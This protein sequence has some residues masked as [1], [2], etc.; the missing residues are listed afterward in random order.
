MTTDPTDEELCVEVAKAL[1][2]RVEC[3]P[4]LCEYPY[5][6]RQPD[7]KVVGPLWATESGAWSHGI[8]M[9]T[10]SADAALELVEAMRAKGCDVSMNIDETGWRVTTWVGQTILHEGCAPTLPIAIV[11]AFLAAQG[12][13]QP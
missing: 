7:G 6:L 5:I 3:S 9:F 12:D 8:P 4:E 1:G 10:R 11:R 2:W 13:K